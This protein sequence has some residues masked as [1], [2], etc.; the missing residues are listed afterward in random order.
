MNPGFFLKL[1]WIPF[2]WFAFFNLKTMVKF[3][4][5]LYSYCRVNLNNRG[6]K[7]VTLTIL[8][9]QESVTGMKLSSVSMSIKNIPL[10]AWKLIAIVAA[11]TPSPSIKQLLWKI[12]C[13]WESVDLFSQTLKLNEMWNVS[14][15][16]FWLKYGAN[17]GESSKQAACLPTTL[18]SDTR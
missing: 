12:V 8:V 18:G 3:Y 11:L 5:S 16:V 14:D 10:L 2:Y 17:N 4:F 7:N 6:C 13:S 1:K 15:R 9:V